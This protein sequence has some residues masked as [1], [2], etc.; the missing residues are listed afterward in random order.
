[1]GDPRGL[2]RRERQIAELV[3]LARPSKEVAYLFGISVSAVNNAISRI[4]RKLGISTREELAA[5]FAP[6]GLR[7]HLTQI[8][9]GERSLLVGSYGHFDTSCL[10]RLTDAE[11]EI[12]GLLLQGATIRAIARHRNRSE[13]TVANQIKAIYT[14][15]GVSSRLELVTA[16]SSPTD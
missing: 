15:L 4:R 7:S 13:N 1:M 8:R 12:A 5:F 9:Q 11:R 3:G 10:E 14:K 2:T 16:L 6:G